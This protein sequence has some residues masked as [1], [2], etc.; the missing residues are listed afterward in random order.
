MPE[1][2]TT[3]ELG[4]IL[5]AVHVDV[6]EIVEQ[7]KTTNGRVKKLEMW[8]QFLLGAW[9]VISIASPMVWYYFDKTIKD[10]KEEIYR[11]LYSTVQKEIEENN[12]KYFEK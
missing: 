10:F 1:E 12:D 4:I 11:D 6:K 3:R 8:K 7:V 9:A 2:Y 5:T